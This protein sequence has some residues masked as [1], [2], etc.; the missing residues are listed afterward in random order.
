MYAAMISKKK[1][2][3]VVTSKTPAEINKEVFKLVNLPSMDACGLCA[4]NST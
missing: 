3:I 2:V 1:A 4:R